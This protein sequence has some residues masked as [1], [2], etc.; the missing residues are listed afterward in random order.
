MHLVNVPDQTLVAI[1]KWQS[2]GF[3]V[4]YIQQQIS[5]FVTG[6]SVNMSKQP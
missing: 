6:V 1:V 3:M 4:Y 5:S 2:L